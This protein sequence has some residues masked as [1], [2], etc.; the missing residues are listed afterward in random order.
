MKAQRNA[1]SQAIAVMKRNGEDATDQIESMR[2][3]SDAI[4][5]LD[6]S[7]RSVEFD[8]EDRLLRIPNMAH[9]SVPVGR[10]ANDNVEVRRLGT[11]SDKEHRV[12]H[13]EISRRLGILDFE[14]G[15]KVTGS[16][17]GFYV[18]KGA[19]LERAL[20]SYFLDVN[21]ERHGYTEMM[22][23]FMVNAESLRGTGQLPKSQEDMYHM[24]RD[25][26]Y[27][28]PT[29]EVP[30]TNFHRD[31][32]LAGDTLPRMYCGY[33]ACFRR[34]A[35]SHGKETRGFL[36][37]HQFNKIELVKFV[38]PAESYNELELLVSNVEYILQQLGLTYRVLLL[39][40]GDMTFGG[41]KTYDLEVWAPSEQRWL[42]V[43]SCTNFE[44]YQARR[45]DIRYKDSASS[46][47]EFLHTLNGSGLATSRIMVALLEQYQTAEGTITIPEV[48]RPYCGFDVIG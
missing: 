33:S 23:P 21:T 8:I 31:E 42:E 24:E 34:E 32:I 2:V 18:G 17:F 25:D 20:L 22:P 1:A 46:K 29:A 48:L 27:M 38:K 10:D 3:V 44:S 30:I 41:A 14:R 28:I 37:V 4:K 16:G 36:R 39:C 15:A 19:K 47:P 5:D 43:S 6:E 12:D 13:I 26:L 7:L 45:A 9:D 11:C 35:G 40:T